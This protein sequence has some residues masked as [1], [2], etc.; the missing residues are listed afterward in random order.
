MAEG[1][2]FEPTETCASAVFKTAAFVHS[3]IPPGNATLQVPPRRVQ[4][5]PLA[6]RT[7]RPAGAGEVLEWPIRTAC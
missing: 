3:A 4:Y 5:P 1:V 6:A 7:R 2:G